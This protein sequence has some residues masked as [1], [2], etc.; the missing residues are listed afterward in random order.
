MEL[1]EALRIY[2]QSKG[3]GLLLH[4]ERALIVHESMSC[5]HPVP[6]CS[7]LMVDS[8]VQSFYSCDWMIY[9][10]A[11]VTF[12]SHG[13]RL[14]PTVSFC[15]WCFAVFPGIPEQPGMSCPGEDSE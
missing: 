10:L 15:C 3:A 14:K 8:E 7:D 6:S 9:S 13:D 1:R 5:V 11:L 12:F 4:G 2:S